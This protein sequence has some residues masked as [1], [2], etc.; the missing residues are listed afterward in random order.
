[1]EFE[2]VYTREV[3]APAHAHEGLHNIDNPYHQ[4]ELGTIT[5]S[6]AIA[7]QAAIP[8]WLGHKVRCSGLVCIVGSDVEVCPDIPLLD[9]TV[10]T[11]KAYA[12]A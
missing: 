12:G 7:I 9:A 1:M 6:L 5:G 3:Y 8:A 4:A 2:Y 10:A 11:Y